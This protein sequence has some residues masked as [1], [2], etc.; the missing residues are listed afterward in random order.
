MSDNGIVDISAYTLG[1][2]Q[3]L[4]EIPG[5]KPRVIPVAAPPIHRH[6]R[7]MNTTATTTAAEVAI[8]TLEL[9]SQ[10][11]TGPAVDRVIHPEC[12]DHR[13][14]GRRPGGRD[15]FRQ[16]VSWLNAGFADLAI[17]PQDIIASDNKVAVRTR[18][19]GLHVGM[20]QGVAPTQRTVDCEQIHIFR[21]ENGMVAEHW[22]C[23]DELAAF[24]QIGVDVPQN[25]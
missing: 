18:F 23:M 16:M 13:G 1:R 15:G 8:A 5:P 22:M 3:H 19:T 9:I 25:G 10:G 20:F 2:G 21:V 12:V 14:P 17:T 4:R 7:R 24:S 11:D 6:D